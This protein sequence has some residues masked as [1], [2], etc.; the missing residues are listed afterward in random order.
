M[1]HWN[2][3][4][5]ETVDAPCLAAFKARLDEQPDLVKS[6]LAHGRGVG[7]RWVLRSLSTQSI[8][9]F[10]ESCYGS[11]SNSFDSKLGTKGCKEHVFQ[12]WNKAQGGGEHNTVKME[13]SK[14][15]NKCPLLWGWFWLCKNMPKNEAINEKWK[16]WEACFH[17]VYM[18]CT[19]D[20]SGH[21][22]SLQLNS[23]QSSY[24]NPR[25]GILNHKVWMHFRLIRIINT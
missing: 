25:S 20:S 1:R 5:R 13:L 2:R 24:W 11:M 6:V 22:S 15:L 9:W 17:I 14:C 19:P 7:M 8:L 21:V 23:I 10:H 18:Y 4:P 16:W 12:K 3:V